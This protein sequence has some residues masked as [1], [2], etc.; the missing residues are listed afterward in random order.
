MTKEFAK[1]KRI[2][3]SFTE[4]L[5][6]SNRV[7]AYE[8]HP[9]TPEEAKFLLAYLRENGMSPMV[10]GSGAVLGHLQ[11][12]PEESAKLG[13]P[14]KDLDISINK[15]PI[16]PIPYGWRQD[17]ESIGL[18]SWISPSGGYV[19]FVVTG[20]QFPDGRVNKAPELEQN[21]PADYPIANLSTIFKM[22]L[23][24][25]RPQDLQDLVMLA[26]KFGVPELTGLNK[27]QKENLDLVKLWI[28]SA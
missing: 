2:A 24:S 21:S 4:F 27:Q 8:M 7:G 6:Y 3:S 22:K 5:N 23:C 20:H 18:V 13:R 19:D 26:R 12:T 25:Y 17:M 11:I 14:T 28:Q 9:P 10:V 15:R 16:P 1:Q